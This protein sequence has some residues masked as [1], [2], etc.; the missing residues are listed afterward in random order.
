MPP[1]DPANPQPSLSDWLAKA[2][3]HA[4]YQRMSDNRCSVDEGIF[5]MTR[6]LCNRPDIAQE[7]L[8]LFYMERA[9]ALALVE[10]FFDEEACTQAA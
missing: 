2:N 3:A 1:V 5:I 7:V 9:E 4:I 10:A 6:L 8:Q